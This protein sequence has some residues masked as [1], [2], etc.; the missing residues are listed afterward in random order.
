MLGVLDPTGKAKTFVEARK[1]IRT[2]EAI[3]FVGNLHDFIHN[4]SVVPDQTE[5]K[6]IWEKW[7]DYF[8]GLFR[9]VANVAL[10]KSKES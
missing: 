6:M 3:H 10:V 2:K 7:H 9:H 8:D 1:G 4:L 5:V